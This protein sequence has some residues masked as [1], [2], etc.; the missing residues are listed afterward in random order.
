MRPEKNESNNG[1]DT[2][3]DTATEIPQS[4]DDYGCVQ[5]EQGMLVFDYLN[6]YSQDEKE[7][8][9]L[10]LRLCLHCREAVAVWRGV[11][12]TTTAGHLKIAT[13]DVSSTAEGSTASQ[14]TKA[15]QAQSPGEK[16]RGSHGY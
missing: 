8:V 4:P 14:G 15:H 13:A 12:R 16:A 3:A 9:E 2:A 11:H 6:G 10:H 1:A 7:N 5:P